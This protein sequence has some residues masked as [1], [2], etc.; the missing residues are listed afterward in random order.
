MP[1]NQNMNENPNAYD[2]NPNRPQTGS[3]P[4]NEGQNEHA[5][6][7]K[8]VD[9]AA[10]A[11]SEYFAPGVGG[12]A[13]DAAKKVPGVGEA[14]DKTTFLLILIL[15]AHSALDIAKLNIIENINI[16]T[17]FGFAYP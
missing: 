13:Y 9:T 6:T 3:S 11:A 4:K 1:D 7:Q 15:S 14:I 10:K 2:Y 16:K 12:M 8:V 5:D 17:Y